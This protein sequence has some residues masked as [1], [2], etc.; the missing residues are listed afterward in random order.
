MTYEDEGKTIVLQRQR[1]NV[2]LGVVDRVKG[3]CGGYRSD[4]KLGGISLPD[5]CVADSHVGRKRGRDRRAFEH[6]AKPK[7]C[8]L[9]VAHCD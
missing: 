4:V 6:P 8:M 7:R 3:G 5:I 2:D 9:L 1:T